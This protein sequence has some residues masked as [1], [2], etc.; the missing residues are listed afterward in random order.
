MTIA[1]QG[2]QIGTVARGD[3][4]D[5]DP[6]ARGVLVDDT[7]ELRWI[8]EG[9]LPTNV[10]AWFTR[11]GTTGA[12]E[13]RCDTY[14]MDGRCDRG[15]KLRFRET[16]ELKVRQ[17]VG[18]LLVLGAGLAGRLQMWRKWSPAEGVADIGGEV[19]W[20]DVC[21]I[22]TKRRFSVDGDEIVPSD[23]ER[24][25]IGAGCDTEVAAITVGGIEAWTFAF[26]AFGPTVSR[27]HAIVTA[28]QALAADGSC[29][30]HFAAEF[31]QSSS[32]PEW[33]ALVGS[34]GDS[35]PA[36]VVAAI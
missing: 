1:D 7:T 29:L 30:E 8:A 17:E 36:R 26:A 12:V 27:E 15:V 16:L 13:E 35:T 2:S 24:G 33:L 5:A 4:L 22:V 31:G 11:G 20:H 28:W 19:P 14:R 18:E 10:E 32:Y 34:S 3:D 25:V 21:K 9:H 23:G 6:G